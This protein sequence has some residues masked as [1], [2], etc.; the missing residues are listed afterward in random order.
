MMGGEIVG[1]CGWCMMQQ[2]LKQE[3]P[4]GKGGDGSTVGVKVKCTSAGA[5][6]PP[7]PSHR[8]ITGVVEW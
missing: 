8:V 3:L 6:P 7:P 2:N 4:N 1:A 5:P